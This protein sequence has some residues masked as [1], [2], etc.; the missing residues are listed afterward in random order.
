MCIFR[1]ADSLARL[2]EV[3]AEIGVPER[4]EIVL[5]EPQNLTEPARVAYMRACSVL[6]L[7][8]VLAAVQVQFRGRVPVYDSSS[9]WRA[10]CSA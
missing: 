3:L 1:V 2:N 4:H 5:L 8:V 9:W 7:P 10:R 6:L